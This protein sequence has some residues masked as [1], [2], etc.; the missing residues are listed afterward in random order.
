MRRQLSPPDA[1]AQ[2]QITAE[3]AHSAASWRNPNAPGM[4]FADEVR[5]MSI[6]E[7]MR[8]PHFAGWGEVYVLDTIDENGG[9]KIMEE[10][11]SHEKKLGELASTAICGNDI[12]SS[13]FYVTGALANAAGI[14]APIGAAVAALTLWLFRWVYTEAVT[15]LPF[16][17]GIYNILL[18]TLQRKKVAALIATLTMLSY[19]ATAVVSALSAGAYMQSLI[20]DKASAPLTPGNYVVEIAIGL[21][22]FFCILKLIGISESAA[23]ATFLF[24]VH[25]CTM[26]L[27]AAVALF[28]I[29][30]PVKHLPFSLVWH[31]LSTNFKYTG[32]T[33]K[34]PKR[35]M[36]GF[37]NAM[38]GVS[39]FESSANFVEE[40]QP[41]VFP[42]TLRNMW[43]AVSLLNMTFILECLFATELQELVAHQ[44]QSLS[45]MMLDDPYHYYQTV[46]LLFLKYHEYV[47]VMQI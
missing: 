20:D 46:T 4:V 9:S 14:W 43:Y 15:A 35:V 10:Q 26:T 16:N 3:S 12:T 29:A 34:F 44:D 36:L 23:V 31:N 18:N 1:H 30:L 42:K 2:R 47:F 25:I 7:T 13:C 38:L 22:V 40:Q 24:V 21:I 27:L 33:L 41:G 39:G 32:G 5:G 8:S 17:G 6:P 37:A 19:V 45:L 11:E 28:A